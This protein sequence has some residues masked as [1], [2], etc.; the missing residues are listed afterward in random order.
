MKT[1]LQKFIILLFF[2]FCACIPDLKR[3]IFEPLTF[4]N[5]IRGILSPPSFIIQSSGISY[6]SVS[7]TFVLNPS[8]ATRTTQTQTIST[9][10]STPISNVPIGTE[11]KIYFTKTPSLAQ[12]PDLACRLTPSSGTLTEMRTVL[13]L[14]CKSDTGLTTPKFTPTTNA[15]IL[16]SNNITL[17][18]SNKADSGFYS[19]NGSLVSCDDTQNKITTPTTTFSISTTGRSVVKAVACL[20]RYTTYS[21]S[22]YTITGSPS[23]T[24]NSNNP[25]A[26]VQSSAGTL[27]PV[28]INGPFTNFTINPTLPPGITIDASTGV[29]SGTPSANSGLITYTVTATASGSPITTTI[30]LGVISATYS[31][32]PFTLTQNVTMTASNLTLS[33]GTLVSASAMLPSGISINSSTGQITGASFGFFSSTNFPITLIVN[34]SGVN[35][36]VVVNISFT[37]PASVPTIPVPTVAAGTSNNAILQ[38]F[39]STPSTAQIYYTLDGS[40]P[41]CTPTGSL[42]DPNVGFNL[43]ANALAFPNVVL[44]AIAC[45]G[46]NSSGLF[47]GVYNFQAALPTL[48][49][50]APNS[51]YTIASGSSITA[52]SLRI[53]AALDQTNFPDTWTCMSLTTPPTCGTSLNTCATGALSTIQFNSTGVFNARACKVFYTQ[54]GNVTVNLTSLPVFPTGRPRIWVT[55]NQYGAN[56]TIAQADARC[57]LTS[58]A[59]HPGFGASLFKALLF[60]Y[61]TTTPNLTSRETR[62]PAHLGTV[63]SGGSPDTGHVSYNWV[64]EQSRLYYTPSGDSIGTTDVNDPFYPGTT[65]LTNPFLTSSQTDIRFWSGGSLSPNEGY[66]YNNGDNTNCNNWTSTSSSDTGVVGDPT[67]TDRSLSVANNELTCDQ[68]ARLA[69]VEVSPRRR[70]FVTTSLF[71]GDFG[72]TGGV[73]L[74]D[75][76]CMEDAGRPANHGAGLFLSMLGSSTRSVS[77]SGTDWVI[78]NSLF[79]HRADFTTLVASSDSTCR[80]S[81]LPLNINV[82]ASNFFTGLTPVWGVSTNNCNDWTDSSV[83]FIGSYGAD[84]SISQIP[85]VNTATCNTPTS[86]ACI[87]Q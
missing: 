34:L 36:T 86:I 82:G 83:G 40:A 42:L 79:Y 69:C 54:S 32:N 5:L 9:N 77:C 17:D 20:A 85:F 22:T 16:T 21:E 80:F 56:M 37:V 11:Y 3:S 18:F 27:T 10:T 38:N 78:G 39:S 64:F 14:D 74:A 52:N 15:S 70:I 25:Y 13:L 51:D 6:D 28:L 60:K 44:R 8:G 53:S 87:E 61:D 81:S 2:L 49:V 58:D 62:L 66:I 35:T 46:P 76:K 48:Y 59:N 47:S 68:T 65:P 75:Q 50:G 7:L 57:N 55:R 19:T 67:S 71:G 4:L 41:D 29:I 30:Q 23:I 1:K 26:F 72:S 33:S 43:D 63:Y 84:G 24:Y 73:K 31:G 45:N 12:N